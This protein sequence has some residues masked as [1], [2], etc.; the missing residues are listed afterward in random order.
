MV[1]IRSLVDT[2]CDDLFRFALFR[3]SDRAAAEDLVQETFIA[4]WSS[5]N[6]FNAASSEKTWLLGILKHK[7]FDYYRASSSGIAAHIAPSVTVDSEFDERGAWKTM[8]Q[9]WDEMPDANLDRKR[10]SVVLRKCLEGLTRQQRLAFVL[11]EIDGCSTK[12]ICNESGIT[13]TNLWVL[14]HRARMGLRKCLT[15]FWF[16]AQEVRNGR[17]DHV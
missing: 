15:E 13:A 10:F 17:N 9:Q 1:D 14:L 3:T 8:P 5:R 16:K 12:E 4:A 6:S 7:L 11:R 2:Y